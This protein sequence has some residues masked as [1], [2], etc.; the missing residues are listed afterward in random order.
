MWGIVIYP[1][2][3]DSTERV[4]GSNATTTYGKVPCPEETFPTTRLCGKVCTRSHG[5]GKDFHPGT[6]GMP[7]IVFGKVT[8][9]ITARV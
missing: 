3:T 1:S 9:N 8:G 5:F 6:P 4:S 2:W 7:G